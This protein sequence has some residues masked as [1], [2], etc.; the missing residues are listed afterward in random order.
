MTTILIPVMGSLSGRVGRK[1]M[2]IVGTLAMMAS[3]FAYFWMIHQGSVLM[4]VLAT[5]IGLEVSGPH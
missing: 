3:A 2:Y 4:L 1:K 5:I